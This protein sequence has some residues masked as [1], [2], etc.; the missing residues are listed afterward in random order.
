MLSTNRLRTIIAL[1][2]AGAALTGSSVASAATVVQNP[3]PA[4]PV[5]A[6][7]AT[8]LAQVI[9]P[10]KVFGG[11]NSGWSTARCEDLANLINSDDALA[12]RAESS[13]NFA[14][15]ANYANDQANRQE[16]L[17][18]NCGVID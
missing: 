6:S 8:A 7:S 12:T 14:E 9:D 13:G 5:V 11:V 15:A 10:N 4:T 3:G 1:G 17:D 2:A 18:N 16:Q